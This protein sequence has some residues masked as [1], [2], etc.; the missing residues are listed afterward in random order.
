M[1]D[2]RVL[3]L[4]PVPAVPR[5]LSAEEIASYL[6]AGVAPAARRRIE[7]HLVQCERCLDEVLAVLQQLPRPE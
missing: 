6:D 7:S 1:G 3:P 4:G 2:D 5:H